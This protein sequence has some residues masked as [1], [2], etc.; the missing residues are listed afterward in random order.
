ME[1]H[2]HGRQRGR[3]P[4]KTV[5]I[6]FADAFILLVVVS[7]IGGYSTQH[8]TR[9]LAARRQRGQVHRPAV[10]RTLGARWQASWPQVRIAGGLALV[11]SVL[12]GWFGLLVGAS[13]HLV[14]S[15]VLALVLVTFPLLYLLLRSPEAW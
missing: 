7:V 15:A 9:A 14:V 8:W 12:V 4:L 2:I 10:R 6:C 11:A 1:A 5:G 3:P 13:W